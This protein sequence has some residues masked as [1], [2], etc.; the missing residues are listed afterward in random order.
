MANDV[1]Y[2]DIDYYDDIQKT[3]PGV[4]IT[5]GYR[6]PEYQEDMR[7]RGYKPAKNSKHLAGGSL[8]LTPPEGKTRGWLALQIR[9]QYPEA[10]V[11][12]EGDHFHVSFPGYNKAP[13]LGGAAAA[14]LT[15]PER[16]A[17]VIYDDDEETPSAPQAVAASIPQG[18]VPQ[19]EKSFFDRLTNAYKQEANRGFSGWLGREI[20]ALTGI[21]TPEEFDKLP[22]D[23]RRAILNQAATNINKDYERKAQEDPNGFQDFAAGLLGGTLGSADPTMAIMA[24]KN[25]LQRMLFAGAMGGASNVAEQGFDI[26]AGIRDDF[27]PAEVGIQ[28]LGGGLLQGG[29]EGAGRIFRGG[30]EI[31][32]VN[33]DGVISGSD[34][35][36]M[37]TPAFLRNEEGLTGTVTDEGLVS[38]TVTDDSG[39]LYRAV[40][41]DGTPHTYLDQ[42]G[43]F[44]ELPEGWKIEGP[45]NDNVAPTPRD[46]VQ[47]R[48]PV[49]ESGAND[50][51]NA[52]GFEPPA[53]L[54]RGQTVEPP[55]QSPAG[56]FRGANE[57]FQ[58]LPDLKREMPQVL[59][60]PDMPGKRTARIPNPDDLDWT[61]RGQ[62]PEAPVSY[63]PR[64]LEVPQAVYDAS[65]SGD[66]YMREAA[67]TYWQARSIA[68]NAEE[69]GVD[70]D[71]KEFM[72]DIMEAHRR[73]QEDNP[74]AA[75]HAATR[76]VLIEAGKRIKRGQAMEG[77]RGESVS[78]PVRQDEVPFGPEQQPMPQGGFANWGG[79]VPTGA[80]TSGEVPPSG[81]NDNAPGGNAGAPPPPPPPGGGPPSGG[82]TPPPPPP[83]SDEVLERL[84][85]DLRNAR[86]IRGQQEAGYKEARREKLR[87]VAAARAA[88]QGEEGLHAEMSALKGEMP[89]QN[90]EG[91]RGNYTQDEINSLFNRIK[92]DQRFTWFQAINARIGLAKLLDGTLPTK[93]ELSLLERTFGGEF[94]QQAL[95]HRS[96]GTKLLDALGNGLN[97]PRAL[98]SSFDLSAP[99]RQGVFLVRRGKFWKAFPQMFRYFGSENAYRG[100]MDN[101]Y[102]SPNYKYMDEGGL[103]LADMSHDLTQREEAFI[104]NWAEKIPGIGRGVRA[105]DRAYTGFLNKL[106]AD[107]FDSILSTYQ[108]RGINLDENPDLIKATARY[109]NNATGRGDLGRFSASG[110]ILSGVLFSPRLM[111]SRVNLLRPD[112]YIRMPPEL[113]REAIKDLIGFGGVAA[114]VLALA[115]MNGAEVETD[116]RST[117]FAKIKDGDTRYDVL[118][119]FQQYLRLGAQLASNE[120]KTLKGD[121][122]ELGKGYGKPTRL[123]QIGTFFRS[124][125][126]PVATYVADYLAGKNVVGEPFDPVNS[127]VERFIPL[128]A[129]DFAEAVE[130]KGVEGGAKA[131]PGLF[132]VGVQTIKPRESTSTRVQYNDG[133]KYDDS[134]QVK[135][136]D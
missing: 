70:P 34:L 77:P 51:Q 112:N 28:A 32:D 85:N 26:G 18:E 36:D 114:T 52:Y 21:N 41:P 38:G 33:G 37:D 115:K 87:G 44:S 12:D 84:T 2:D 64:E 16:D 93:S 43:T 71:S 94:V 88:T 111:A 99:L 22:L 67:D 35:A 96:R 82:T 104:S 50:N 53:E 1:I 5:S 6:T 57:N 124:K 81:A 48:E 47:E 132:G 61:P 8:D 66:P 31:T 75:I 100:L 123:D 80:R 54:P 39:T 122:Q 90:F 83:N 14:G 109:I 15:N 126:S 110:P 63:E 102:T 55:V 13:V 78:A 19:Q 23:Q 101:I 68:D 86:T 65:G 62:A 24:G 27:S 45:V 117:D 95:R 98:M 73:S 116:P 134:P 74:E 118:G 49:F 91:V 121:V 59:D 125:G 120:K 107:T 131:L 79:E 40:A 42:D 119:G 58:E 89:K 29:L 113:R 30:R 127:A 135:Y 106:R 7:R 103:S 3:I 25:I 69:L 72:S 4:G 10:N 56:P 108:S 129:Q 128:F 76:D 11:L 92:D 46:V 9:R 17:A 136:S 130:D 97:L 105:S 133:V 60:N 20:M